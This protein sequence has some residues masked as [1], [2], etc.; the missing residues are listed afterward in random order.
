MLDRTW[1]RI[2]AATGICL[3]CG[4]SAAQDRDAAAATERPA[5]G[6]A[7]SGGGARGGAHIGVLRGLEE[8]RVPIDYIAGTSIGG[9]VGGL[10]ASGMSVAEIEAFVNGLDWSSAFMNTTPR[11]LRS[12]RRKR[13][14]DLFLVEQRP[15][16]NEGEFELPIGVV[17][18]Q[19]IDTIMTREL[20]PVA[21]VDDF[22]DLAIPFR[23]VAADI[24]T[25]E[26]VVLG[27]GDLSR[28]I[29][30][31]MAVPAV[32]TP[33]EIDGRLLV[34]GG[35]AMNLPVE[36]AQDMGAERVIAIDISERLSTREELRSVLDV[37]EQLTA[38]LTRGGTEAQMER[39]GPDDV[40]LRPS[41]DEDLGSMNFARMADTIEAGYAAVME[42]RAAFEA[43]ALAPDAYAR[44][45][46]SLRDPRWE[47]RPTIDFIRIDND[48]RIANSV[49][50][51]RLSAIELGEPLDVDA[52]ESAI[53]RVYGLELYQ[54]V[55]YRVVE[56][57]GETGLSI[58]LRGRSWGPNYLQLGMQYSSASDQ[59]ALFG[60]A[61]S[62]LR[63]QVNPLGGEWRATFFV[64]DE[65][66]FLIDLYQPLGP[67]ALYF[68]APS[69]AFESRQLNIFEDDLLV[70][71]G[72]LREGTV[73]LAGGR[74][75]G[76]WGEIR[77][78]VRTGLGEPKLRVGDQAAFPQQDFNRGE[79]FARFSVDTLDS[80]SFPRSGSFMSLEWLGSRTGTLPADVDY[81]QLLVEG[82]HARTW[83][84]HTLL[85]S[86]R[87]D[88][89]VS[90]TAPTQ[91]QVRFG[92][93][94]D[95]SGLNRD[96]LLGQHAARIGASY[97]RRIGD[98]S[99]FPAFAGFSVEYG[100]VWDARNEVSIENGRFGGS[101]WAGVD[102]PVGPVY[103]GYGVAEGGD[104][105]FYV[106]LGRVF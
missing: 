90:G 49:I 56:D 4:L 81:D 97:Y 23:A 96:Q 70:A 20:L 68:V 77:G 42:N 78:G 105:A 41:L 84:R 38:L 45:R 2:V 47:E 24:A 80:I 28:A 98:L 87:Y 83:G 35:I 74:V 13:D 66:K 65:P 25:A 57:G 34:D 67:K 11:R 106:Y 39:L 73:E 37:T 54:T 95:L 99:L 61:A 7:L 18:G 40:L 72:K 63:T 102:T 36:V 15:G 22:D 92:G 52:V 9:A 86:L 64:G 79:L 93:F 10:Y 91:G 46:E 104:D 94:F 82:L 48:S 60:L 5:V 89:T 16:W 71:E 6:L 62:Y 59:D 31:S 27:S 19:V 55:R 43:L 50:D 100:G 76:D 101:F 69:I 58:D 85:S 88:A 21:H 53:N 1:P 29:R 8:L 103:V 12:F 17:Q 51:A 33:I 3:A 75:L 32:L 30:A 44:Y 26:R 14:D